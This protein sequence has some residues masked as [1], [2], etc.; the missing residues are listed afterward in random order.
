MLKSQ[1]IR[2]RTWVGTLNVPTEAE[3]GSSA[4]LDGTLSYCVLGKEVGLSGTPHL[5]A[6]FE[7]SSRCRMS[8]LK[9]LLKSTRWH[10]EV[11][12]GTQEEASSYCKKD[13]NWKEYGAKSPQLIG[14]SKGPIPG[15]T[16]QA[17]QLMALKDVVTARGLEGGFDFDFA[18][19]VRFHSGLSK[20]IA[21]L[22]PPARVKPPIVEVFFGPTGTGKTRCCWDLIR[23]LYNNEVYVHGGNPKFF[24]GYK[25]Q[26]VVLFDDFDGSQLSLGR[27][28]VLTDRYI[29][30]V[31]IKGGTVNWNPERI[32]F[33]TNTP[34]ERWYTGY[35]EPL[36]RRMQ[37]Y[38]CN[39]DMYSESGEFIGMN[40]YL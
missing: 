12:R 30:S 3:E 27:I 13:G 15:R 2:S 25:G 28:K 4:R 5:Q 23:I 32:L 16:H 9:K 11:R 31:E 20:Y 34:V 39:E 10:L 7:L 35:T 14:S 26:R 1:D 19:T 36:L 8:A 17:D 29:C 18:N 40:K 33:T 37:V 21:T 22:S 24:D 6:Y 38:E